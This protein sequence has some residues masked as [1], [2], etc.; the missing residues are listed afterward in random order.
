MTYA[1]HTPIAPPK[2]QWL[3]LD[4]SERAH[5]A[6]PC[7]IFFPC[8]FRVIHDAVEKLAYCQLVRKCDG[9]LV[10]AGSGA[11]KT[12][13]CD[14]LKEFAERVYGRID[15][16]TTICPVI[17]ITLT[18]P[19]TPVEISIA[20]LDALGDPLPR[21]GSKAE[22]FARSKYLLRKCEVRLVL[23]DNFHDAPTKRSARGMKDAGARIRDLMDASAAL[24]VLLG[25]VDAIAVRN[26]DPQLVRRLPYEQ[27]L[28]Y[29]SIKTSKQRQDFKRLLHEL[30]KWLPLA[31]PSCLIEAS[32][33]GSIF[34]ATEGILDRLMRLVERGWIEAVRAGRETMIFD[35]LRKAFNHVFGTRDGKVNPFDDDFVHRRLH[36]KGEPYEILQSA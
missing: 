1:I 21:H 25:T 19:C 14:F 26:S 23:V 12:K 2:L 7:Y 10:L 4:E 30:D 32:A 8:A 31:E 6:K 28:D 27:W 13:L 36:G 34:E 11:G 5:W 17:Q 24:W 3:D 16:E 33:L 15:P 35:D 9:M 29:F 20:V 18:E 22:I